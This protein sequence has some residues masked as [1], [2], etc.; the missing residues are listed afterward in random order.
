MAKHY[1][2]FK[3]ADKKTDSGLFTLL[4]HIN[5][6]LYG[7]LIIFAEFYIYNKILSY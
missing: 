6:T 3:M 4:M 2:R 5:I 7:Y 1:L